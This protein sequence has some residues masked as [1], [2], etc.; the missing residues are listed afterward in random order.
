[1]Q[2][3]LTRPDSQLACKEWQTNPSTGDRSRVNDLSTDMY[4][5]LQVS[6]D[7]IKGVEEAERSG[8][9]LTRSFL[10]NTVIR[11]LVCS[12][13]SRH[14]MELR[15]LSVGRV[16]FLRPMVG[17]TEPARMWGSVWKLMPIPLAY[18]TLRVP[19]L[20]SW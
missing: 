7:I 4:G 1:M 13:R 17:L 3:Q 5:V 6:A 2:I 11:P 16:M 18:M 12:L 14:S 10:P 19:L 8:L 9:W 15:P 20:Q